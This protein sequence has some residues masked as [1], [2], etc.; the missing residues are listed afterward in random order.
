MNRKWDEEDKKD[1][2]AEK[3]RKLN[4][5]KAELQQALRTGDESLIKNIQ[6]QIAE[7]QKELNKYINQSERD[8]ANQAFEDEQN[9][10]DDELQA[11]LDMIEEK[12]GDEDILKLVQSGITDLSD[13]LNNIDSTTHMVNTSFM[14]VADTVMNIGDTI[15]TSWIANLDKVNLK[16]KDMAS[17]M[18]NS[19]TFGAVMPVVE[20]TTMPSFQGKQ[21]INL[22]VEGFGDVIINGKSDDEIESAI[23]KE[24]N[25]RDKRL[26]H[27][28]MNMLKR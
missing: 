26:V 2:I 22:N 23:M 5:L 19:I 18:T 1:D 25:E 9:R 10:L 28:I 27:Q 14:N 4:E 8:L 11:K 13:T 21:D 12:L 16:I 15:G 7:A 24:L 20:N 6:L 17:T 3:Q